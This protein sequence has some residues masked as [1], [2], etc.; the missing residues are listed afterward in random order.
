MDN[1]I[2]IICYTENVYI[3]LCLE[4][5]YYYC[6]ICA[7]K[8]NYN[9]SICYRNYKM[10]PENINNYT[11]IDLYERSFYRYDFNENVYLFVLLKYYI[12]FFIKFIVYIFIF[13]LIRNII[14]IN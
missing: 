3:K 11:L 4:C 13:L 10:F 1:E 14:I 8:I 7:N 9:C 12:L 5:N 2:C 6:D